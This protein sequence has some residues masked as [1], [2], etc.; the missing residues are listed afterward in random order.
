LAAGTDLEVVQDQLGYS[1]VVL[2]AD[3]YVLPE[4]A[5]R[6][7]QATADMVIKAASVP[8]G[9]RQREPAIA[10]GALTGSA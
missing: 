4:T 1:T 2:T 8:P 6:A 3:T 9:S 10:T 5:N 7:G